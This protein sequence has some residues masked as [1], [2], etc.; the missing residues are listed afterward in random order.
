MTKTKIQKD[1]LDG[2]NDDT[3]GSSQNA[4]K[5]QPFTQLTVWAVIILRICQFT[6]IAIILY[7]KSRNA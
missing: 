1:T 4:V 6:L 7:A 5:K 3:K 2:H